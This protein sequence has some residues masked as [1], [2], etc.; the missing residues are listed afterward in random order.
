[1]LKIKIP[2]YFHNSNCQFESFGDW[3]DLKSSETVDYIGPLKAVKTREVNFNEVF[4]ILTDLFYYI[5]KV[6]YE[7]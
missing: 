2:V 6:S 4:N 1:M 7:Y 5:H 3:I